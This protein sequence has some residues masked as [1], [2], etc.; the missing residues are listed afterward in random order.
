MIP[1]TQPLDLKT[2]LES[3]Q[4]FRWTRDG[5]WYRGVIGPHGY[6]LSHP[7]GVLLVRTSAA[8]L[9]EA[10]EAVYNF[11]RLDDDLDAISRELSTDERLKEA[12]ERYP[13]LRL[14]RQ[15]PWECLVSFVCSS[16]SNIRHISRSLQ[17]VADAYGERVLLDGLMMHTFP[18]PG[19]LAME[20][21]GALRGLGLGFHG[22]YVA[23]IATLVA[24]GRLDL[25][26]LRK[27]PY[28][29]AKASLTELSGV[30]WPTARSCSR[31]TRWRGFP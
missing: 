8:S 23:A 29:D 9:E 22:K 10:T 21:E 15:D 16:A 14:L 30:G 31:W 6:A 3:G 13:G 5:D 28:E 11:L 24:E 12:V 2:T 7:D 4:V 18:G 17:A 19:R 1:V 20:G 25:G 26:A 27:A